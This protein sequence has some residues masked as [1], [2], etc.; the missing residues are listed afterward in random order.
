MHIIASAAGAVADED[1]EVLEAGF[2]EGEDGS[3]VAVLFQRDLFAEDPWQ[4]DPA[5]EDY[6][7]NSYCVTQGTGQSCYGG[8]EQISFD[9][10]TATITFSS[11]I[12]NT[13]GLG[14]KLVVAFTV[15]EE[16]LQKFKEALSRVVTWGTP[17][18]IPQLSGW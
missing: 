2:S 15:P 7:S 17:T 4:G 3:G 11:R 8:V 14:D 18:Q 5:T 12:A 13:L 16:D 6:S 9:K 1:D 10:D